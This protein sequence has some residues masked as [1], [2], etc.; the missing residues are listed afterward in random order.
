M[1]REVSDWEQ[2]GDDSHVLYLDCG[3]DVVVYF[4]GVPSEYDCKRCGLT[5]VVEFVQAWGHPT[6]NEIYG[7]GQRVRVTPEV[8]KM[9]ING[10]YAK[11]A[12]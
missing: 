11:A 6:R 8:A 9:L 1:I 3:H 12:A 2:Y 7:E 5:V 10:G 4:K